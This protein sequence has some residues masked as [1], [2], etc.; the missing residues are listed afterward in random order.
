MF[1]QVKLL[2]GF[3]QPLLYKVPEEWAHELRIGSI[4]RVPIQNR[5]TPAVVIEQLDAP[6]RRN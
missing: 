1:I 2:K 6:P 4:V 3:N 5:I